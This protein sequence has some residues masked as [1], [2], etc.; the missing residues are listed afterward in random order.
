MPFVKYLYSL[1]LLHNDDFEKI[2]VELKS[3]GY[4]VPLEHAYKRFLSSI[5]EYSSNFVKC[6]Y[7]DFTDEEFDK[8]VQAL[9]LTDFF[10]GRDVRPSVF[11]IVEDA[12]IRKHVECSLLVG[13]GDETIIEDVKALYRKDLTAEDIIRFKIF[14]FDVKEISDTSSYLKYVDALPPDE[15]QL[16][17]KCRANGPDF[18]RWSL[19]VDIHL[20]AKNIT[21]NMISDAYF[22]FKEASTDKN[23]ES[24][25]KAI[26]LGSLVTKL[27]DREIKLDNVKKHDD[28]DL[29]EAFSEQLTLFDL[30]DDNPK[31]LKD[32]NENNS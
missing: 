25:D 2:T 3:H 10:M 22:R 16:K 1:F 32:L 14:F 29:R 17:N 8:I 6:L 24:F 30:K 11:N 21:K 12:L 23:I 26:K 9:G 27:I 20:N 7:M 28:K 4:S 13:I 15:R 18:T 31:D 5:S 19:G